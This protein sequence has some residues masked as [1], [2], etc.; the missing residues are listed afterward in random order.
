MAGR[1]GSDLEYRLEISFEEAAFGTEKTISIPRSKHAMSA[2][3]QVLSPAQG[4]SAAPIA[5]AAAR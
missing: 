4:Q 3:A 1:R 5:A 2:A